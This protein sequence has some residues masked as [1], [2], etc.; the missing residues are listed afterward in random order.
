LKDKLGTAV[1]LLG[2]RTGDGKVALVA[3][4]TKDLTDRIRAGD[5]VNVAAEIVGGRGGGRP[6]MARAGGNE[7]ERLGEALE[8]VVPYVKKTLIA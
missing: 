7:P 5:V 8:T 2:A 4:V 6:D 3:G 1:I